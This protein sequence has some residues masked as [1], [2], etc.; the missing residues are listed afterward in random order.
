M[1]ERMGGTEGKCGGDDGHRGV[2]TS[3]TGAGAE[4]P[5]TRHQAVLVVPGGV[6]PGKIGRKCDLDEGEKE[7]EGADQ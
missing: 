7:G 5:L 6:V 3:R 4:Q 1:M 2:R